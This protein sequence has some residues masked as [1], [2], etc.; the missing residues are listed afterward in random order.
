MATRGRPNPLNDPEFAKTVAQMYV[1]GATRQEMAD[2]F[3][4]KDLHTVTRWTKDPRVRAHAQRLIADREL[5]IS[6]KVDSQI[7]AKLRNAKDMSIREL[8]EIRKSYLPQDARTT[9][10]PDK[11]LNAEAE[12]ALEANPDLAK[13]MEALLIGRSQPDEE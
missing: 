1:S 10:K 7:E 13:E 12:K 9:G 4:V 11:D 8:L 6:R 2:E 5:Q 3:N